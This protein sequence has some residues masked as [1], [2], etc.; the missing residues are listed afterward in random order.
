MYMLPTSI[1]S[2][3]SAAIL[4]IN[5][6]WFFF[7]S[8]LMVDIFLRTYSPSLKCSI[9]LGSLCGNNNLKAQ[10]WSRLWLFH[11]TDH[12]ATFTSY[13][14]MSVGV[15]KPTAEP[16]GGPESP[17]IAKACWWKNS[18]IWDTILTFVWVRKKPLPQFLVDEMYGKFCL[19]HVLNLFSI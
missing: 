4:H 16:A 1:C 13:C 12:Q 14:W 5:I 7:P 19:T 11:R 2:W 17:E 15:T 18:D 10:L 6:I 8:K 3:K 9:C